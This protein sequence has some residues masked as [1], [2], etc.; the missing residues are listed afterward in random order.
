MQLGHS[1]HIATNGQE[2]LGLLEAHTYDLIISDIRMPVMDG[3]ELYERLGRQTPSL[4]DRLV[5]VTGDV[6]SHDTVT[7]GE[8]TG[9]SI[10]EKPF[11]IEDLA[12][13]IERIVA[14]TAR[15][16]TQR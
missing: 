10:L 11:Q 13:E 7:F 6:L 14:A 3:Q 9:V 12:R 15:N 5:F 2:A 4:V 1:S 16:G 8:K